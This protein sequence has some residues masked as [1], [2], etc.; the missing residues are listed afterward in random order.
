MP[1]QAEQQILGCERTELSPH[2][3]EFEGLQAEGRGGV[4]AGGNHK[5]RWHLRAQ[6]LPLKASCE[7]RF[8]RDAQTQSLPDH[9]V[10][11]HFQLV[12]TE[13]KSVHKGRATQ[14][15]PQPLLE[16]QGSQGSAEQ[17][18]NQ[19]HRTPLLSFCWL[20]QASVSSEEAGCAYFEFEQVYPR[21]LLWLSNSQRITVRKLTWF[22]AL[23][24]STRKCPAHCRS[25]AQGVQQIP[26]PKRRK[27][28]GGL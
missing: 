1:K 21:R 4:E 17:K 15:K 19:A 2:W 28:I 25:G 26:K 27:A 6:G 20:R 24:S 9:D 5:A 11:S 14:Q 22:S 8:Q 16:P 10:L 12:Q 18:L 23:D 13:H 7:A 3:P